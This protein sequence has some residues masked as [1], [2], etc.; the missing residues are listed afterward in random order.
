LAL[1]VE[2]QAYEAEHHKEGADGVE[3][4]DFETDVGISVVGI[5]VNVDIAI[6]SVGIAAKEL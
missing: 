1:S 6:E 4:E 3:G 2:R 5:Q